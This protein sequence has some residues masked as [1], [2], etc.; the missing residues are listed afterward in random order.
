[1]SPIPLPAPHLGGWEGGGGLSRLG[2]L[3][4]LNSLTLGASPPVKREMFLGCV[5]CFL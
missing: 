3:R 1:M 4:L 2:V 5:P